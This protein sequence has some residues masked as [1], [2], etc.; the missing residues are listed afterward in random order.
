MKNILF[1]FLIWLFTLCTHA[2]NVQ[3]RYDLPN[4]TVNDMVQDETGFLWLGTSNGLCKFNG[5]NYLT[6]HAASDSLSLKDAHINCLHLGSSGILW[7]SNEY[8]LGYWTHG[9][10]FMPEYTRYNHINHITHLDERGVIIADHHSISL[11]DTNFQEKAHFVRSHM[12]VPTIM[13][14]PETQEIWV[15]YFDAALRK[16]KMLILDDSLRLKE[17]AE[18]SKPVKTFIP[19]IQNHKMW[20]LSTQG[21]A[22]YNLQSHQEE[23]LPPNLSKLQGILFAHVYDQGNLILGV[24][25]KGIYT[26]NPKEDL[27]LLLDENVQLCSNY[28]Y[29]TLVDRDLIL[30]I[31]SQEDGLGFIPYEP[32]YQTYTQE[33]KSLRRKELN[34]I[35]CDNQGNLWFGTPRDVF[36]FNPR[37]RKIN[38]HLQDN[39]DLFYM[40]ARKRIWTVNYDRI[41]VCYNVTDGICFLEKTFNLDETPRTICEDSYGRIWMSFTNNLTCIEENGEFKVLK[42]PQG[43]YSKGLYNSKPTHRLFIFASSGVYF[44]SEKQSQLDLSPLP[45]QVEYPTCFLETGE[46]ILWIGTL[47]EG[48]FNYNYSTHETQHWDISSGLIS[49]Q[50]KDL[51]LDRNNVLWVT[52]NNSITRMDLHKGTFTHTMDVHFKNSNGY[53]GSCMGS[54]GT[55][56]F[57]AD[58]GVTRVFP[59]RS[60][61]Q[62]GLK[63]IP[64]YLDML[65]VNG[66][67]VPARH[68]VM[69]L[70]YNQNN[71]SIWFSG[72][73]YRNSALLN[74]EYKME[75]LDKDWIPVTDIRQAVFSRLPAG[76]YTFRARVQNLNGEWSKKELTLPFV[77]KPAPWA[78]WWAK[79]L[80][81]LALVGITFA[82]IRLF[83]KWRLREDRLKL[84]ERDQELTK[85]HVDFV[86]NI[87]HELR[88]PLALIKAPL[89]QLQH[90]QNLSEND[91]NLMKYVMISSKQLQ[92]LADQILNIGNKNQEAEP[93]LQVSLGHLPTLATEMVENFRFMASE[94]NITLDLNLPETIGSG[95]FDKEKI[96]K[97]LSNL[98]SNAIKYTLEG[99]GKIL[100][101]LSQDENHHVQVRISDN[102]IGIPADKRENLFQR[103][104]RLSMEMM[105]PQI[106]GSGVGLNYAQYLAKLHHGELSYEPVEPH[107]STFTLTFPYDESQ[108]SIA[109][110]SA[111]E[112]FTTEASTLEQS[113]LEQ[114][115]EDSP[116]EGSVLVVEDTAQVR[117]YLKQ[118]LS[119]HFE[120]TTAQDGLEALDCLNTGF[121]PDLVISDIIMPRMDGF[122]L[123]SELKQSRDFKHLPVLLLTAK[124]DV[125]DRIQGLDSGADAYMAKPFDPYLLLHQAENLIQKHKEI[126]KLLSGLTSDSLEKVETNEEIINELDREFLQNL[127]IKLDNHLSEEG[128][129]VA[130]LSSE[131]NLSYSRFYVKVK[132][133]TGQTPL[134]LLNTYRMN[135]AMEMLRS[136]KFTVSDVCYKVGSSSLANFSRS[137]KRQFGMPPSEI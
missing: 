86:T 92:H 121:I 75:G 84:V 114:T 130:Q 135:K 31:Y 58:G 96:G 103:F 76:K 70:E 22:C 17:E 104:D 127:Y 55:L 11:I 27:V 60:E 67:Q 118:L 126:Q 133:L 20:T 85:Q 46:G 51:Q 68:D 106:K 1:T 129:N 112:P 61:I 18:I 122:K 29:Q 50:I 97:I 2:Q 64:I 9:K 72:L 137:F 7:F 88:T 113:A 34:P 99:E 5:T 94:K 13:G 62:K 10:F 26:Y 73:M 30:W 41:L 52:S 132:L 98:L 116:K 33:F 19:D 44:V 77:I 120:V 71:L 39:F 43:I 123:C 65:Q 38:E 90:S 57:G 115:A 111:D 63:D 56:F 28:S 93:P 78:T 42:L 74:Y 81:V 125:K 128:F 40:D 12:V 54:D 105:L 45:I 124:S 15:F 134:N 110:H 6:F 4:H 89:T 82:A 100:V 69:E 24:A 131:M 14:V 136:R 48:L 53:L 3:Y 35:G 80:Y 16:E 95:F 117:N 49:N 91:R 66:V 109:E 79:L 87:S 21:L 32:I 108:Y 101:A 37:D 47:N 25:G 107:G 102:G 23:P 119:D 59:N 36:S 83:I 8:G